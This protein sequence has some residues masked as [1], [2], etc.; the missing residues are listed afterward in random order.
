MERRGDQHVIIV[1][2]M[3]PKTRFV[4]D[5]FT[6]H[7]GGAGSNSHSNTNSGNNIESGE[8]ILDE[9]A[10]AMDMKVLVQGKLYVSNQAL[11][12]HSLWN[13]KF[14]IFGNSTKIKVPLS[15]VKD[16]NKAKNAKIFDNS[17]IIKLYSGSDIFITSFLSR[18]ECYK[19]IL[20]QMKAHKQREGRNLLIQQDS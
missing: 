18:D 14:I 19:L 9:Y 12:F 20:K 2:A 5:T 6:N 1:D 17:I 10:C 7:A 8:R 16:V 11:Y 4:Y 13:D 15:N 3:S